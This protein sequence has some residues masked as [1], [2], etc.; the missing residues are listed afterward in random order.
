MAQID[1]SQVAVEVGRTADGDGSQVSQ[2]GASVA[3]TVTT[4]GLL[5]A[6]VGASV[7]RTVTANGIFVPQVLIE[8]AWYE[9]TTKAYYTGGIDA[10]KKISRGLGW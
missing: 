7:A 6:Q 5:A 10:G 2:V 9:P 8:V 3:R 4:S 1:V